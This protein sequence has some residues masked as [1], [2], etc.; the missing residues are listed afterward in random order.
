[1]FFIDIFLIRM[2]GEFANIVLILLESG[3]KVDAVGGDELSTAL[4]LAA[5]RDNVKIAK[6]LLEFGANP[7]KLDN[8][9]KKRRIDFN[10]RNINLLFKKGRKRRR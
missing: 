10:S 4:H 8:S 9:G 2:K 3:A 7:N 5:S 6:T 1:M